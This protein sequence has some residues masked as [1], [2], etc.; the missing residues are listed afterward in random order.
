MMQVKMCMLMAF[1][2]GS[3]VQSLPAQQYMVEEENGVPL[4][5]VISLDS[6]FVLDIKYATT[7]NFTEKQMYDCGKC[8]L[9]EPVAQLLIQAHKEL[10]SLGYRIKLWDC[11]RPRPIQYK[12]WEAV[13]DPHYVAR[14]WKGSV[15]N[16]GGAVDLTLID[17]SGNE[18]DMG[19]PYDFFGERAHHDNRDLPEEI[20]H[21]R[22]LLTK[23]MRKHQF[24][25]IRTVWWHF[26]FWENKL[27]PLSD[28]VW[29]CN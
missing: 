26:D 28:L 17:S 16:R 9:R 1:L 15:H 12:L 10:K 14:P 2:I 18:V 5:E 13:P 24:S 20:L 11:Y 22:D 3:A 8:Y 4:V 7:D 6:T 23:I 19:T 21:N 25:P 27:Y 29:D